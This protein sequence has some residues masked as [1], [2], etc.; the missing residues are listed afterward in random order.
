MNSNKILQKVTLCNKEKFSGSFKMDHFSKSSRNLQ[1]FNENVLNCWKKLRLCTSKA[2]KKG[3]NCYR[4][5]SVY[6]YCFRI[7]VRF[8][9]CCWKIILNFGV[10]SF[11][12]FAHDSIISVTATFLFDLIQHGLICIC[13]EFWKV[14]E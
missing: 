14:F 4:N 13:Y 10:I 3:R 11:W 1:F 8:I 7:N 2:M 12:L 6:E 5:E 9:V